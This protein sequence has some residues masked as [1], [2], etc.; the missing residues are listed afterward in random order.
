MKSRFSADTL[1]LI[2][3]P[4][5]SLMTVLLIGSTAY[6]QGGGVQQRDTRDLSGSERTLNALESESRRPK[7]DA[8]T[9]MTEVNDDFGRLRVI[10]EEIK[11]AAASTTALNFKAISDNALEIKKRGARLR[12]NLAALPKPE[13]EDKQKEIVPADDAQMRSLLTSVNT[14]MTSFLT[15][16]VFSDMG[17][18]DNQLAAKARRDL[19]NLLMLSDVLKNGAEKLSKRAH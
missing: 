18:L 4:L 2:F 17:T 9:I 7:R 12:T 1:R 5:I 3:A 8:Q 6:G 14:V 19:D 10:N 13:K 15:N 16:P 11:T